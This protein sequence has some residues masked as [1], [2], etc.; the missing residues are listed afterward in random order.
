LTSAIQ[1]QPR[2]RPQGALPL[3]PSAIHSR[4]GGRSR[5][6]APEDA[7]FRRV[8]FLRTTR[9]AAFE[10]KMLSDFDLLRKISLD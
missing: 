9:R 8:A 4:E 6:C 2:E 10:L 7:E 5:K 1:K 3:R